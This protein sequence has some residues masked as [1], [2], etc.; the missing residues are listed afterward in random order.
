MVSLLV[1]GVEDSLHL[2]DG[3]SDFSEE[4]VHLLQV[5]E[6]GE[7]VDPPLLQHLQRHEEQRLVGSPGS[8]GANRI[9]HP[10]LQPHHLRKAQ[11]CERQGERE[12]GRD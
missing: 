1:V 3:V 2:L 7:V 8:E 10:P 9:V 11:T 5:G 12:K 6:E 4:V